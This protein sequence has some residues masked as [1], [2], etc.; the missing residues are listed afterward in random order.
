MGDP[1]HIDS[2]PSGPAVV[3]LSGGVDS[4][5]LLHAV[6]SR[7]GG[8]SVHA[9]SFVYGQKHSR[10]LEAAAWQARTAGVSAHQVVDMGFFAELIGGNSELV[11]G[12]ADVSDLADLSDGDRRHPPTYVPNRNMILLSL[13]AAHAESVGAESLFYGAQL[14]DEYGYWDCTTGFVSR[15]NVVLALNRGSAVQVHAPF[16]TMSKADVVSIGLE[17]GVDYTQTWSCY[18]G[19]ENH[20]GTCPTCVE[21]R[22]AFETNGLTLDGA[23]AG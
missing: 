23:P 16:A 7:I 12:G 4:S 18:R 6:A 22:T 21:R 10:E 2:L 3:L 11:T 14:H 13:A 19:G 15:L 8:D 1:S 17:L 20:C 9:L 5:T